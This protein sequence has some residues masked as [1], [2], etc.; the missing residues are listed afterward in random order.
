MLPSLPVEDIQAK[1]H[2]LERQL[3][4][5]SSLIHIE[6]KARM[7]TNTQE[8]GFL[9]VNETHALV[10]YHQAA[11]WL[12]LDG[13]QGRIEALSGV[14]EPDPQAP[15]VVWLTKTFQHIAAN[16]SASTLHP[17][18]AK[19]LPE[20]GCSEWED[21][22]P[23]YGIWLPL[24]TPEGN[25]LGGFILARDKEWT[26]PEQ[27]VLA[28]I[29]ESYAYTLNIVSQKK[30][31]WWARLFAW[32]Q[33]QHFKIL[34]TLLVIALM[35]LPVRQSALAPAEVVASAPTIVR[36]PLDGVVNQ[37]H[38]YPNQT[39][40][41]GQPLL[42]LDDVTLKNRLE[43]ARKTLEI[44]E[45]KYRQAAQQAVFDKKSQTELE[46]FKGQMEKQSAEV[47]YLKQLLDKILILAPQDGIAIFEDV[48]EWLG[49]PVVVGEKILMIADQ[50]KTE[51][52]IQLPAKD[53]ISLSPGADVT[54]FLSI[55]PE[56]PVAATL[57]FASYNPTVTAEN[58][59]AYR[60][61]AR[62]KNK[63]QELPR[64][65]LQG[66][67]KIYGEEVTL[68]YYLFRR[69]LAALRQTLGI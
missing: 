67:A 18:S 15:Y 58:F 24:V 63:Q 47:I 29:S 51:L 7:A 68:F 52:A 6:K 43:V 60:L 45:T 26:E 27:R 30:R 35:W 40:R 50:R 8:V 3:Q 17:F 44:T 56:H 55:D 42:N 21:W 25:R 69:P 38:I 9:V 48:N 64:I 5:L 36:A 2:G 23:T 33:R 54:L 1:I 4:S 20:P 59:L 14:V 16:E 12:V 22:F 13:A 61:K 39:I 41:A 46:L 53:A 66:T 11:L 37:F 62:F 28:Y 57:Y 31:G 19:D 10:T 49:R 65:G 32:S 34:L